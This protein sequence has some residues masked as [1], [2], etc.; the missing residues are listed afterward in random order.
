MAD[1]R[2]YF[3]NVFVNQDTEAAIWNVAGFSSD[4]LIGAGVSVDAL[5]ATPKVGKFV[6]KF[7]KNAAMVLDAIRNVFRRLPGSNKL[8]PAI[9]GAIPSSAYDDIAMSIKNADETVTK[10][11]YDVFKE[12]AES[13]GKKLNDLIGFIPK[14]NGELDSKIIKNAD[15][16]TKYFKTS[17]KGL[18][19]FAFEEYLTKSMNGVGSFKMSN[20]TGKREFDGALGNIW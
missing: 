10:A 5:K 1:V 16:F 14:V 15:D 3:A 9:A 13:S 12:V 4:F 17:P 20:K 18:T 7:S 6:S 11:G 8:V 2:D 19:D